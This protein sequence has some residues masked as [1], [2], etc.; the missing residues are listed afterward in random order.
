MEVLNLTSSASCEGD[1]EGRGGTNRAISLAGIG[2][3]SSTKSGREAPLV[4]VARWF[5]VQ[6]FP[7]CK[8]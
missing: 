1:E 7:V 4:M 8:K 6:R 3:K 2:A 5:A